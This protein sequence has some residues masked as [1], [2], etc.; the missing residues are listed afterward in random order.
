MKGFS[1]DVEEILISVRE[2]CDPW[3]CGKVGGNVKKFARFYLARNNKKESMS[4]GS[5]VLISTA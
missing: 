3:T 5:V 1:V 4:G 2:L